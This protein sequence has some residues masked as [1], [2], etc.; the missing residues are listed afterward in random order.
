MLTAFPSEMPHSLPAWSILRRPA[1]PTFPAPARTVYA[2]STLVAP[3]LARGGF[4]HRPT[5]IRRCGRSV[6][7][8]N[9]TRKRREPPQAQLPLRTTDYAAS[10]C[11]LARVGGAKIFVLLRLQA[12]RQGCCKWKAKTKTPAFQQGGGKVAGRKVRRG[13]SFR[14]LFFGVRIQTSR[15]RNKTA[16]NPCVRGR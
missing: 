6:L 10:P 1:Q 4:R 14:L 16:G 8:A 15:G 5:P 3:T 13:V 7:L 2:Q 9:A 12:K 11:L